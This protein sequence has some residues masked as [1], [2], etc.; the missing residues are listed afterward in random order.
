MQR[1]NL[2]FWD[3]FLFLKKLVWMQRR[4]LYFWNASYMCEYN[5]C[6]Q[7]TRRN[8]FSGMCLSIFKSSNYSDQQSITMCGVLLLVY[9]CSA[10]QLIVSWRRLP[11][12][13]GGSTFILFKL[14][15]VGRGVNR[16][17]TLRTHLVTLN[18]RYSFKH[19]KYQWLAIYQTQAVQWLNGSTSM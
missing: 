1:R 19:V 10:R 14:V 13:I 17:R 9:G 18:T 7:C 16:C 8:L 6:K 4:N 2:Y 3:A 5:S 11:Y 15:S 12:C